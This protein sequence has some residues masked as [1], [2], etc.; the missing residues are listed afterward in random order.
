M[1]SKGYDPTLLRSYLSVA[2]L[3]SFTAAARKLGLQQ[4]TISQHVK[5]LEEIIGRRLLIRDTHSVTIT[6]DGAAMVEFASRIVEIERRAQLYFATSALRGRIRLGVSEDFVLSRLSAVLK[7]YTRLNPSVDLELSVGLAEIL[8]DKLETGGLDLL[9]SKRRAGDDR[10]ETV[11][12]ERLVWMAAADFEFASDRPVPLVTFPPPSITRTT[13]IEALENAGQNWRV[14]CTSGS[15]SGIWA[16]VEAGL[17]I[18]AQSLH[19]S[20]QSLRVLPFSSRLPELGEV[21]FVVVG[22]SRAMPPQVAALA[23]LITER[24][25]AIQERVDSHGAIVPAAEMR[26]Q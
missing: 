18:S 10:G 22:A 4:S 26:A 2:E 16:A 14:T 17:G 21:E 9:F 15:L 6:T 11:W 13:A 3:R 5:R 12:R 25:Y 24:G 8:Y 19:L 7:H 1:T 23:R 20:P